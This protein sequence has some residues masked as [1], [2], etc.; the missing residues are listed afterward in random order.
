MELQH[1]ESAD[2]RPWDGSILRKQRTRKNS[3]S[4]GGAMAIKPTR[5]LMQL[6][7]VNY[8]GGPPI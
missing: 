8:V 4:P 7:G 5:L 2:F 6:P 3:A 1:V